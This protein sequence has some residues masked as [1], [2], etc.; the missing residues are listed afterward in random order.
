MVLVGI[1]WFYCVGFRSDPRGFRAD[2]RVESIQIFFCDFSTPKFFSTE[3]CVLI[4]VNA[5][6]I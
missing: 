3:N 5:S 1:F 4:T 2:P 6:G